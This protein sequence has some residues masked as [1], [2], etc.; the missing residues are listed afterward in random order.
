MTGMTLAGGTLLASEDDRTVSCR[1]VP[2]GED[3]SSNLGR[4][5]VPGPGI[6]A[7]PED[8]PG[9]VGLNDGHDRTHPVG[10]GVLMAEAQDGIHST[11]AV[12]RGAE[13][14]QL[15][16]DIKSGKRT[17]VS[18]EAD[19]VVVNGEA[20]SGR[21]FGA[22][23]VAEG[24][25][26][27]FPSATLFAS[28][29][30]DAT[31]P[32]TSSYETHETDEQGNEYDSTT[33]TE[34]QVE[35]DPDTGA[36][37]ITRT[38]TT[39]TTIT[40][41]AEAPAEG[42]A[43]VPTQ[44]TDPNAAP[45]PLMA[46]VPGSLLS[47]RR[48]P[49]A[50]KPAGLTAGQ[51]Y[52][53][54]GAAKSNPAA[55]QRLLSHEVQGTLFAELTDVPFDGAGAPGVPISQPQWLGELWSGKEYQRKFVPL[56][57]HGELTSFTLLGWRWKVKPEMG[58]WTG[59][60]TD[61]P[62]GPIEAE[63]YTSKAQRFAGAHDIAREYRDFNVTEFWDGYFRAMTES[64]AK[65]SDAYALRQMFASGQTEDGDAWRNFTP[66]TAG[67]TPANVSPVAAKIV[68][69]AL[70]IIDDAT[71]QWAI[72]SKPDYRDLLLTRNE[73]TLAYLSSSL[74]LE[75]G[76]LANFRIIPSGDATFNG[77]KVAVGASQTGT[78]HELTQTPI[79]AEGLDMVHGGID[80]S[81]FGYCGYRSDDPA[82]LALVTPAGA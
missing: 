2:F 23:I 10:R 43:A 44:T 19:V 41:A 82:S 80:P 78:F 53:M 24:R 37:T 75:D 26:P 70:A 36:Q 69:G 33:T 81:L 48:K 76:T 29:P 40:P 72:V 31:D 28:A 73:D 14:D 46:Q 15:L 38:T 11:F 1:L 64:Y 12:A 58:E 60:K 20:V 56:L 30:T 39:V 6:L 65:L 77:G 34:E 13:G 35:D 55:R 45:A 71:P 62:S 5:R 17:S 16:A 7:I 32:A 54:L 4:F 63:P 66:I 47:G 25:K 74:G 9:V 21:I 68:D 50:S 3:C 79:R 61:V 67:A 27:A 52:A 51:V 18:V 49:A 57:A 8:V 22:A 59:N 42:S